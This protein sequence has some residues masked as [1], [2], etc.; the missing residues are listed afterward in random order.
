MKAAF[1]YMGSIRLVIAPILEAM[2]AQVVTPPE[3]SAE[4]MAAGARLA[5]ELM[6]LPFKVTLGSMLRCLE[7]GADTLVYASGSWSCRF[8]YYGRLQA[9]ILRDAGFRFELLE[10]RRDELPRIARRV[11]ALSQ[12]SVPRALLR[13]LRGIRLGWLTSHTLE[14]V[15]TAVRQV[16]PFLSEHRGCR[17]LIADFHRRLRE[18]RNSFGLRRSAAGV[19]A[20]LADLPRNERRQALRVK[21][22]GE[23]YCVLEPFVNFAVERRLG[24]LGVVVDPFLTAHRWMGFHGLRLGLNESDRARHASRRYWA[25]C[26]GG[27]DQNSLGH[28]ILAAESGYDG[29]IHLHPLA[30]MPSTV[31]LPAMM[32]ASRDVDIPLLSM[33]LDEHTAEA[34]F[35]TRL[36]AFVSMLERRRQLRSRTV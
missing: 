18:A 15:E 22:V 14:S 5:P 11:V 27:E 31:V 4:T 23:S 29:V 32:R 25:E 9:D 7:M 30:C 20:E 34:G 2:G 19:R 35:T 1:P 33:S 24:E 13:T 8:G 28:L 3:P 12:G 6:C 26:V 21:L 36:E 17:V 10:L 16:R